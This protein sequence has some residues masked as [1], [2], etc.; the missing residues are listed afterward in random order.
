MYYLAQDRYK[1]EGV[2]HPLIIHT[3]EMVKLIWKATLRKK[4]NLL[5][6]PLKRNQRLFDTNR[7]V[8][9]DSASKDTST[10]ITKSNFMLYF[11]Y[12]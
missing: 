8:K 5:L 9:F 1:V 3:K 10:F 12:N 2:V 6:D 7:K 11:F 4:Y